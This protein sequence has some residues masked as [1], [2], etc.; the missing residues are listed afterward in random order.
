M[1]IRPLDD[2][3]LVEPLE[4]EEKT[5]GGIILPDSAREKPQRGKIVAVGPGR[6][7]DNGER[8]ALSVK[9]GDEVLYGRYA[10]SE[11]KEGGKEYK[12]MRE[13]DVLAKLVK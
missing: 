13:G 7:R 8:T 11:L 3:I 5:T 10:G 6:L 2:R 9:V 4:A 1:A 12:V